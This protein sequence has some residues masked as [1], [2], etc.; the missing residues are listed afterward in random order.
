MY[1]V[2]HVTR[3][4]SRNTASRESRRFLIK[5]HT[6]NRKGNSIDTLTFCNFIGVRPLKARLFEKKKAKHVKIKLLSYTT[7]FY[8]F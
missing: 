7:L 2:C 4:Q 3:S 1:Y 5:G 8:G 6:G